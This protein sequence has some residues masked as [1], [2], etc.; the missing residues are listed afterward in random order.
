MIS[1]S[2]MNNLNNLTN[3]NNNFYK[4]NKQN[5][6]KFKNKSPCKQQ[7]NEKTAPKVRKV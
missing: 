4:S 7:K 2:L 5:K 3:L 6:P 1:L